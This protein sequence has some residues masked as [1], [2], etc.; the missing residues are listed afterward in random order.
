LG[1]FG[2]RAENSDV[3]GGCGLCDCDRSHR[4]R[5]VKQR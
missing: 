3:H 1:G 4:P 2:K 5:P